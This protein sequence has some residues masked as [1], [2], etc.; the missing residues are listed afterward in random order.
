MENPRIYVASLSDYNNGRLEGKWFDFDDY[1]DASELMDAITDMLDEITKKYNDGEE[2]EEWAVHDYEYIPSTLATEYMGERDF[3]TIYD[4]IEASEEHGIP[5]EVL[6]ERVGDTGSDDYGNIAES[7][8]FVVDGNDESDIVYE[9]EE[10]LGELGFDFW[11]NHI[12]IDDV[13]Q[14]VM[15]GEDLQ[16]YRE[17]I[18]Y[19]NPDMD[20]DEVE[21]LAEQQANDEENRRNDDLI[22]YLEEMEYTDIPT[23][24]SKDY[25]SAWKNEESYN[26]DIINYDGKMYVFSINYSQGG[27]VKYEGGGMIN[28]KYLDSLSETSK[29][30]ILQNIA[31]HYGISLSEA[32]EEV[33]DEDAE[34]LYEYIANNPTLRMDVYTA[35]RNKRYDEGGNVPNDSVI[36]NYYGYKAYNLKDYEMDNLRM[37]Y[38][39]DVLEP[40]KENK[41]LD[42]INQETEV[43][44]RLSDEYDSLLKQYGS[45]DII[46]EMADLDERDGRTDAEMK[47]EWIDYK[48]RVYPNKYN[49]GGNVQRLSD[50]DVARIQQAIEQSRHKGIYEKFQENQISP[51]EAM[52]FVKENPEV[53]KLLVLKKGGKINSEN[54][55]MLRGKIKEVKHHASELQS[56]TN[57]KK[58][59]PAWVLAKST[60]ASTDLSDITHYMDSAK[61]GKGGN[62]S[63][64]EQQINEVSS[65]DNDEIANYLGISISQVAKDRNR[66][67]REA[68]SVMMLSS[69]GNG[70][71]V[72]NITEKE[73]LDWAKGIDDE[74]LLSWC[75]YSNKGDFEDSTDLPYSK[76]NLVETNFEDLEYVYNNQ[77]KY[78][79]KYNNGGG[80]TDYDWANEFRKGKPNKMVVVYRIDGNLMIS[81][82][83]VEARNE[84]EAYYNTRKQFEAQNP[85]AKIEKVYTLGDVEAGKFEEGGGVKSIYVH[86][87][88]PNITFEVIELTNKGV[89]GL[90]KNPKSLSNKEKK[91]GIIVSYSD[92]ELK[93]LFEK[94]YDD[95]GGVDGLSDLIKG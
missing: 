79:I 58:E 31:N 89:K 48:W 20:E 84:T 56:I 36:A 69:Y 66:Y 80:I 52:Q 23:W 47:K 24:V 67:V 64:K 91:Q 53:L 4:I 30:K 68:Q 90:Q 55:D 1:S 41:K 8:M 71:G 88:N 74:N 3:Q 2:R 7:L 92:A 70:G 85:N 61:F 51:K 17:D 59:V 25:E 83:E 65:W 21:R 5:T 13:T 12:Y 10:Q 9:M 76:K 19:E 63:Y 27:N 43:K 22:G 86:K 45:A 39:R 78:G 54:Y 44:V 46:S 15:Y 75:G 32:E 72:G 87:Y 6:M 33:R 37:A 11:Q 94:K 57:R 40:H 42:R 62:V 28:G 93:E 18:Q 60:R 73:L 82:V 34:M 26:Y 49:N 16:R 50:E 38:I 35:I 81:E 14:R 29:N 95:G 77:N